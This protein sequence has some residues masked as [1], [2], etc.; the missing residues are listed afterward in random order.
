MSAR[1]KDAY[2]QEDY[3]QYFDS[4]HSLLLILDTD[5]KVKDRPARAINSNK[6]AGPLVYCLSNSAITYGIVHKRDRPGRAM[7]ADTC[8]DKEDQCRSTGR[9]QHLRNTETDYC[10][11]NSDI[12]CGTDVSKPTTSSIPPSFGSAMVKLF[13]TIPTTISL[14]LIPDFCRYSCKA[15][16]A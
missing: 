15:C 13:A 1:R 4:G 5:A 16:E 3:Q 10:R 14:A 11:A 2:A 7:P 9:S 8:R 6:P 12:I